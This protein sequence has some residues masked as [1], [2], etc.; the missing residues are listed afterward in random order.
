MDSTRAPKKKNEN[1]IALAMVLAAIAV[2]S[3]L[4][5]E[6]TYIAQV[7]QKMAF[8]GLDQVK[9]YY[10]AKSGL[11]ISLLRLKAYQNVK[12]F[13]NTLGGNSQSKGNNAS[14]SAVPKG[15]LDKIWSFPFMYPIPTSIPGLSLGDKDLIEKFQKES[16]MD[17]SFSAL[18]E[19]ESS[20]YN[21]NMILAPFAPK[22]T[23]SPSPSPNVGTPNPQPSFDPEA[24]RQSLAEY[25]S[26]ILAQKIESDPDFA[27]EYR[28]TKVEDLVDSIAAWADP[29]YERRNHST[30]EVIPL[31]RGPFYSLSE[32]HMVPGFDDQLY[33]LFAPSLTV[34]TTPG[35]NVN[36]MKEATLKALVPQITEE[37][38]KEFFK[39]RD[40]EEEDNL[41]RDPNAEDFFTYL[42]NSIAAFHH[43]SSEIDKL[44]QALQKRNIR[45]VVDESEFKITVRSEVNQSTRIIEAWVT[46]N[47]PEDVKKTSDSGGGL[48]GSPLTSSQNT[49]SNQTASNPGLRITF[50]RIL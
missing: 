15:A 34:S 43:N 47:A 17:G 23:P 3:I 29:T 21:L 11:K 22:A 10:L 13:V 41:F 45:I 39:F 49:E 16:S 32:L 6:F 37:E 46:L 27:A 31:K 2:L 33:E 40:S 35:I 36:T 20:R 1:G 38:V 26:Q 42:L 5:T 9:A 14:A 30:K 44:K 25:L 18:I 12:G 19:S 4:V 28:D 50:M 7:N 24:A 48:T 8:D